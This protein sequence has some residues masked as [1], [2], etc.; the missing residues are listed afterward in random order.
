VLI[1]LPFHLVCVGVLA[2]GLYALSKAEGDKPHAALLALPAVGGLL[3]GIALAAVRFEVVPRSHG[4]FLK[5]FAATGSPLRLP[6]KPLDPHGQQDIEET[7]GAEPRSY[8][9]P[10]AAIGDDSLW[11]VRR[12]KQSACSGYWIERT[13]FAPGGSD[14]RQ[15]LP[16]SPGLTRN[17]TAMASDPTSGVFVVGFD[18]RAG[19][20]SW[21]LMRYDAQG[22]EDRS[23]DKS[24]PT[25]T[26]ID[27]AY[28]VRLA[29]DG[30]V[31]VFGES[32]GI[33]RRGT[34][35]WVLKFGPDG[36]ELR[37]GWGK[38]F[39]NAGERQPTMA[40]VGAAADPAGDLYVL[41]NLF[42]NYSVRKFDRDG[43]EL[44]QKALPGRK[45]LAIVAD[46]KSDLLISGAA[47]Y[48]GQAW[49]KKLHADGSDGWEKTV[50]LGDLSSALAVAFD[51]AQN[52][53][54]AGYGTSPGGKGSY[55]WIKKLSP[56]GIESEGC[57]K[58]LGE[59]NNDNI[60]FALHMNT[61]D[62]VYVLGKGNGWQFSRSSLERWWGW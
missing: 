19:N 20:E 60:P 48:P 32:G 37:D 53:Y 17:P 43:R 47:G 36:R 46:E 1:A 33:D 31:Y 58:T 14:W 4:I 3:V 45:D 61:R 51:R 26:K 21:W 34:S 29:R 62:E 39:P 27:R 23:W 5:A 11:L 52:V 50:A 42:N 35:G 59:Q 55:W 13:G 16:V 57:D 2:A 18:V 22:V 28:G 6:G 30:S 49:I 24:F 15:C 40:A 25:A 7:L 41:L 38:R 56:D 8:H 10:I 12:S 54:A 44:W 9:E